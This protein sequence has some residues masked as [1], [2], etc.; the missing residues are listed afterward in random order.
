MSVI[1]GV[2]SALPDSVL[3]VTYVIVTYALR[4]LPDSVMSCRSG[5]T[6]TQH[7]SSS[8]TSVSKKDCSLSRDDNMSVSLT[9]D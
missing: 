1:T 5:A 3:S 8:G 9:D 7:C 6:S 4:S 2:T